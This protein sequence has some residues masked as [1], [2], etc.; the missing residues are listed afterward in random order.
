MNEGCFYAQNTPPGHGTGTVCGASVEHTVGGVIINFG[1][2]VSV[3]GLARD[4]AFMVFG[5]RANTIK[6]KNPK[7]LTDSASVYEYICVYTYLG[8]K[9]T[10]GSLLEFSSDN[11]LTSVF[12]FYAKSFIFYFPH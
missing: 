11:L 5:R 1:T 2:N 10:L 6:K 3:P 4:R 12:V 8:S 7:K 9:R